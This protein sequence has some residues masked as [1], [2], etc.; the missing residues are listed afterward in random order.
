M[1]TSVSRERGD[2]RVAHA[3]ARAPLL[4]EA[5]HQDDRRVDPVAEDD[6]DE[7][8]GVEVE[9]VQC[10][11]RQR[12]RQQ[13]AEHRRCAHHP[14][15]RD[16]AEVAVDD[17]QHA[18]EAEQRGRRQIVADAVLLVEGLR[19]V[20]GVLDLQAGMERGRRELR[21]GGLHAAE[22]LAIA[23]TGQA[24]A[25]APQHDAEPLFA[26]GAALEVGRVRLRRRGQLVVERLLE[27]AQLVVGIALEVER[28]RRR[29][30]G[31]DAVEQ[32]LR[33][34]EV[35]LVGVE[36]APAANEGRHLAVGMPLDVG[37]DVRTDELG[38]A[39]SQ[40]L[41]EAPIG[42]RVGAVHDDDEV[43]RA[44]LLADRVAKGDD[45]RMLVGQQLGEVGVQLESQCCKEGQAGQDEEGNEQPAAAPLGERD[46]A[47]KEP[48]RMPAGH[49]P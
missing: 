36:P 35:G 49:A 3:F 44:L 23:G 47:P 6:R 10:H 39:R 16:A 30:L 38:D 9:V 18:G 26:V 21:H 29:V 45:R 41:G 31:D 7:K 32:R 24:I 40:R 37:E 33:V 28:Q 46:I 20:A 19:D 8:G 34:L 4:A 48:R 42:R 2:E 14:Q 1:P 5:R 13:E 22:R 25:L 11:R 43:G 17:Q 27:V 12:Q 15:E